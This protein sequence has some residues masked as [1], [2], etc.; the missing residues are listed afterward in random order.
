MPQDRRGTLGDCPGSQMSVMS[1]VLEVSCS[2]LLVTQVI[3]DPSQ[4]FS[5]VENH[6]VIVTVLLTKFRKIIYIRDIKFIRL[7]NIKTCLSKKNCFKI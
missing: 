4:V 5:G 6:I 7:R 3:L 2:A 1:I